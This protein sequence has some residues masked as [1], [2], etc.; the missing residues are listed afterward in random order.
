MSVI[1]VIV[2]QITRYDEAF[3]YTHDLQE[4]VCAYATLAE[5]EEKLESMVVQHDLYHRDEYRKE[6][7]SAQHVRFVRND[8]RKDR[9]YFIERVA[10]GV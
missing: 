5:A 7:R 10:F 1:Y 3:Q 6:A 9:S 8:D 2:K 4:N